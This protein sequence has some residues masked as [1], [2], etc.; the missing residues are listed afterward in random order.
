MEVAAHGRFV[1]VVVVGLLMCESSAPLIDIR[2]SYL[3]VPLRILYAV[4][5]GDLEEDSVCL[6]WV[7]NRQRMLAQLGLLECALYISTLKD[8]LDLRGAPAR[9]EGMLCSSR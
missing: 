4:A 3:G 7:R 5:W 8:G 9:E 2:S 1:L 6:S